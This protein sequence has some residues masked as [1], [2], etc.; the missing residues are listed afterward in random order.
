MKK[1]NI[2]VVKGKAPTAR[3]PIAAAVTH[4]F[5]RIVKN[6]KLYQ[7]TSKHKGKTYE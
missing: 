5:P 1:R 7:R 3:N 6:K 4:L 2:I